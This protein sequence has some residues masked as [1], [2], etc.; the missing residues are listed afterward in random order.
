MPLRPVAKTEWV[1]V[2]GIHPGTLVEIR[3]VTETSV[4]FRV[5][6]EGAASGPKPRRGGGPRGLPIAEF[7][8]NYRPNAKRDWMLATVEDQA[9][10]LVEEK[11]GT[12]NTQ[13]QAPN[14][15]LHAQEDAI[16][17]AI[18]DGAKY[19]DVQRDFH[20]QGRVVHEIILKHGVEYTPV[21]TPKVTRT[22]VHVPVPEAP[23][24][25][26]IETP[27]LLHPQEAEIAELMRE[28]T[29]TFQDIIREY[30]IQSR[31]LLEIMERHNIPKQTH[32]ERK[33]KARAY[34]YERKAR[35]EAARRVEHEASEE[36]YRQGVM[37]RVGAE[38]AE[39]ASPLVAALTPPAEGY[40]PGEPHVIREGR[41]REIPVGTVE[42]QHAVTTAPTTGQSW[43]VTVNVR[44][45]I[46][47]TYSAESYAD[48]AT[49]AL[50]QYPGAEVV[51]LVRTES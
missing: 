5:L 16:A 24:V 48:A 12:V 39:H 32:D 2:R 6:R 27:A 43:R 46:V 14:G 7:M 51:S 41:V 36:A 21:R 33:A 1:S 20:V 13:E 10:T 18:R 17:Q 45:Q 31:L 9:G 37:A 3:R 35:E 38:L 49:A 34:Y 26:V 25:P 28:R 23:V 8:L 50:A 15:R 44:M 42:S 11:N 40:E 47:A 4:W 30:R 19:H 22:E 29:A